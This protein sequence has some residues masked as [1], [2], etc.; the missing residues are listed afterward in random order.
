MV[1]P[2]ATAS[3]LIFISPHMSWW[4]AFLTAYFVLLALLIVPALYLLI[5]KHQKPVNVL[6]ALVLLFLAGYKVSVPV[7]FHKTFINERQIRAEES[8]LTFMSSWSPMGPV[9]IMSN[10]GLKMPPYVRELPW[11]SIRSV[12]LIK[13]FPETDG[14]RKLR[15]TV[16]P[17]QEIF[18]YGTHWIFSDP[19]DIIWDLRHAINPVEA[20]TIVLSDIYTT[21]LE[22]IQE[23]I[24]ERV[25]E[26]SDTPISMP[27]E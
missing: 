4:P 3:H 19:L 20:H 17:Q 14:Q 5:F 23:L 10:T 18:P 16:D 7:Y 11:A 15:I 8:P 2:A 13:T 22:K 12:E 9:I 24:E 27:E 21:P 26:K 6:S 1:E 25:P